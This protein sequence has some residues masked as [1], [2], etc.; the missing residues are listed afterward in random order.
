MNVLFLRT[1]QII[2]LATV[3]ILRAQRVRNDFW[4]SQ[5]LSMFRHLLPS[6]SFLLDLR[7][8]AN[9]QLLEQ[10]QQI[11]VVKKTWNFYSKQK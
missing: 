1:N 3:F 9:A 11:T 6:L 5:K 4:L 7:F 2:G 10:E 8:T